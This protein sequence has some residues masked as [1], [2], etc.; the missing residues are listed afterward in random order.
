MRNAEEDAL[1]EEKGREG[2]DGASR[3]DE[4]DHGKDRTDRDHALE[5]AGL[6]V[7]GTISTAAKRVCHQI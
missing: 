4:E 1:Q 6:K 2:R 3:R 5:A 7:M